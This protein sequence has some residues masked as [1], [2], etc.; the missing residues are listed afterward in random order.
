MCAFFDDLHWAEETLLDLVEHVADLSRDAPILLLCMARPELLERRPVLGRRQV[1]RKHRLAR[2]ARRGR[3]GT[4]RCRSSA[5]LPRELH[6]RIVQIAEGNPLFLEE[7]LALV[8]D[9]GGAKVEVPPT[10]QALLAARLD[11]LDPAERSVLEHGSVEGRTLPPRSGRSARGDGDGDVDRRLVALV[12]KELVRPERAQLAGDDAYRFRHLLIR[13]AAYDALPKGT[14]PTS[15]TA[16]PLAPSSTAR[17]WWSWTRSSATTWSRRARYL[18]ELGRPE[19]P[20]VAQKAPQ[21][22][23]H[24]GPTALWRGDLAGGAFACSDVRSHL[25]RAQTFTSWSTSRERSRR[26]DVRAGVRIN[27]AADGAEKTG[28]APALRTHAC[29]AA[30]MRLDTAGLRRRSWSSSVCC[31]TTARGATRITQV[32]P[33]IWFALANGAYNFRARCDQIAHAA[34]MARRYETLVGRPHDRS[35]AL[36]ANALRKEDPGR[37]GVATSQWLDSNVG[38]SLDSIR[39]SCSP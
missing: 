28:D 16:S 12:R 5:R 3:D 35:D 4:A 18:A 1:E 25:K 10:I 27:E 30:K 39:A 15:T 26:D 32:S 17:A 13:D 22:T 36:Y 34:E 24:R 29:C 21:P 23:R 20:E 9:S 38:A 6:E 11:Q 8:R 31:S 7:M 19:D 2:A 33:T 14:V 37:G